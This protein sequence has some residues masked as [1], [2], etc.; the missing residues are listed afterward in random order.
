MIA[1]SILSIVF[2]FFVGIPLVG[3]FAAYLGDLRKFNKTS[4][5]DDQTPPAPPKF[6]SFSDFTNKKSFDITG[7]AEAGAVIKL[8]FGNEEKE[9]ITD[10][11]GN[12]NFNVDLTSD[13]NSFSAV[14]VDQAGNISQ[15][16][17]T[18][19]ISF[20]DK[21]PEL[22][23]TKPEDGASMFGIT[24]RQLTIQ[25][26]TDPDTEISIN[27][28]FVSVDSEGQFQFTST[29]SDGQNQFNIKATDQAGNVTEKS[30]T[31]NFSS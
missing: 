4:T 14:A 20:D 26:K 18:Y 21:P 15:P 11:N 22:T 12:F 6:N 19:K 24:Q 10:K 16:T 2:L 27:E 30:I 29:M 5:S 3:K 1:I 9:N 23:I 8:T 13:E 28:R 7:T 25:G 17:K 31:V